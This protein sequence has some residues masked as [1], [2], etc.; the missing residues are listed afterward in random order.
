MNRWVEEEQK[1]SIE[2]YV[3]K[4]IGLSQYG[5]MHSTMFLAPIPTNIW[6]LYA[7]AETCTSITRKDRT[8]DSKNILKC[9]DAYSD[10]YIY[11]RG[12]HESNTANNIFSISTDGSDISRTKNTL[13]NLGAIA[14]ESTLGIPIAV[15]DSSSSKEERL[16]NFVFLGMMLIDPAII[17]SPIGRGVRLSAEVFGDTAIESGNII[18]NTLAKE[19]T[20]IYSKDVSASFLEGMATKAKSSGWDETLAFSNKLEVL[21]K[22]DRYNP[23]FA[24]GVLQDLL[25]SQSKSQVFKE[26]ITGGEENLLRTD[27][28]EAV[29]RAYPID[30]ATMTKGEVLDA[31]QARMRLADGFAATETEIK[32][33][34]NDLS[35]EHDYTLNKYGSAIDKNIIGREVMY[36][37][38]EKEMLEPLVEEFVQNPIKENN[39][40]SLMLEKS[41]PKDIQ[42]IF[43]NNKLKNDL[44]QQ[45]EIITKLSKVRKADGVII[46]RDLLKENETHIT[47]FFIK[48]I[49]D[50]PSTDYSDK[51]LSMLDSAY[52]VDLVDP[53]NNE[54]MIKEQLGFIM[55]IVAKIPSESGAK[56]MNLMQRVYTSKIN[57]GGRLGMDFSKMSAEPHLQ[58]I[59]D[60]QVVAG[61]LGSG[62]QY[63]LV[64]DE[65]LDDLNI[66]IKNMNKSN[67]IA[68]NKAY[69]SADVTKYLLDDTLS[70]SQSEMP[71]YSKN[72]VN[73]YTEIK[74]FVAET[75]TYADYSEGIQKVVKDSFNKYLREIFI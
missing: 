57:L 72:L 28:I 66:N 16:I 75:N 8:K 27:F 74:D 58:R 71:G 12:D 38:S 52:P 9:K 68:R 1:Y 45:I 59:Y 50:H 40:V 53:S 19:T 36:D 65:V 18:K 5:A 73:F 4:N 67:S 24:T 70:R 10:K 43:S 17:V 14:W 55:N 23:E 42:K 64:R 21:Y 15:I 48:N 63:F 54:A 51:I 47:D 61:G 49:S 2:N 13:K 26:L 62:T 29:N 20:T 44:S 41:D 22:I 25:E 30:S 56:Y 31:T 37:L 69:T 39:E 46:A 6:S 3:I 7:D 33:L 11:I 35:I 60:D 32:S 34:Y